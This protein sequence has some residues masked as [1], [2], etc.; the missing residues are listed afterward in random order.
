MKRVVL[1]LPIFI[2]MLF[3]SDMQVSAHTSIT[4]GNATGSNYSPYDVQSSSWKNR[5]KIM[6]SKKSL[7][8]SGKKLTYDVFAGTTSNSKKAGWKV[9]NKDFGKGTEPFLTFNGWSVL[10]GHHHHYKDNQAT[11]IRLVNRKT[12][13]EKMFKTQM[14]N[15]NATKDIEYNKQSNDPKNI[16]NKCSATAKNK[17]NITDCNMA[18]EWV[19]FK[20]WLPLKE[21]FSDNS[22][23]EW[24]MYIVKNVENHVVYDT[25]RIP[26]NFNQLNYSNG[27]LNL[28][29]GI[30]AS[31]LTMIGEQVVRRTSPRS[32]ESGWDVGWFNTGNTYNRKSTNESLGTAIW[33]GV[34]DS[35][36]TRW[37]SSAN[38]QF[39]GTQARLTYEVS[40]KKCP[41]GSVVN[42]DQDCQVNVTLYHKDAKTGD[43]L[44]KEKAKATVGK[45]YSY[46]PKGRGHFKDS[47]N[48]PYVAS[49][50]NQ[51]KSGTTP[52]N[53]MTFTFNYKVSL[54]DPSEIIELDDTTEGQVEGNF[55]WKLTK[56]IKHLLN[57]LSN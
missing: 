45:S 32:S 27:K 2:M 56:E 48:N 18:Y 8:T 28:S 26:F 17:N 57:G 41:D 4:D 25:L 43:T 50:E 23:G 55:I 36:S 3:I 30:N 14:T 10:S 37:A 54:P 39:G 47:D 24:D 34:R 29:S 6:G 12:K 19:G 15:L 42:V 7:M 35:G 9:E 5:V 13:E 20:A 1:L 49:P 33:Y 51:K 21:L 31:R 40:Q 44:E 16:W 11:Y 52:N 46:S 38:W 53:N 22:N